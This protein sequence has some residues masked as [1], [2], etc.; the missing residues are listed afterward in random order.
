MRRVIRQ[1][2]AWAGLYNAVLIPLAMS[3]RLTPV[4]AAAAMV[5]SGLL[6]VANALRL[7]GRAPAAGSPSPEGA[8]SLPGLPAE[9]VG[10]A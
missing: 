6:V 3:G 7:Q 1:N 4:W 9:A 2:L 8:R 5:T 10:G